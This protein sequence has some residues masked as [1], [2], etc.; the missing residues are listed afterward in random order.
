MLPKFRA[1]AVQTSSGE[2][3]SRNL[4]TAFALVEQAA[5]AGAQLIAL[6]EMFAFYGR[7]AQILAAAEE[8][9]G[10]TSQALCDLARRLAVTLVAGSLCERSTQ[11]AKGYNTSLI[12][13]PDGTVLAQ[14]RKR[15]LF[16]VQMAGQVSCRES[17]W[18][19]AGEKICAT[20]TDCGR[21][22]LAI[23]YDLRFPELFRELVDAG[24]ELFCIPSA[25]TLATGRDHWE[26]LLRA[27]AIENQAYVIAPN[28]FGQ[29]TPG[30][31]TYGHSMIIDPWGTV[32]ATAADGEGVIMAEIDLARVVAVREQLPALVHRRD[33]RS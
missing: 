29:H 13:G 4:R 25:F 28:Q 26:V 5:A 30:L 15:H 10:P 8:I 9:P 2:D 1:A 21:I 14:Y 31:T 11:P 16:D 33:A 20:S 27:R 19:L 7:P 23:C 24:C 12:I 3:K 32:L 22:G 18:L 6:P 17:S